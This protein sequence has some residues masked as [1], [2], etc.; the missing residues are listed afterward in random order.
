M[1]TDTARR[2]VQAARA[3]GADFTALRSTAIAYELPGH[4]P[5]RLCGRTVLIAWD[6]HMAPA[7]LEPDDS[8]PF[9][10]EFDG[11]QIPWY[12]PADAQLVL[13]EELYRLHAVTCTS[14]ADV[15]PITDAPGHSS[16][17]DDPQGRTA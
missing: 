13:G 17:Q 16:H 10:V 12:R 2:A 9:A 5:C 4:A 11:N 8:G 15:V 1:M 3:A 6:G 14:T 7:A